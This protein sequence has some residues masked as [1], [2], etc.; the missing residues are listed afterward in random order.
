MRFLLIQETTGKYMMDDRNEVINRYFK[1][2]SKI[3]NVG[4][5]VSYN[6]LF[7]YLHKTEFTYNRKD[8][9][10]AT[11]GEYLRYRFYSETPGISRTDLVYLN[12][13]C[14]MFEMMIALSV[15]CEETI[16]D[17]PRYG[18]RTKQWFWQM[19]K[20]LGLNQM[21]D[22]CFDRDTFQMAIDKFL[23]H[24]YESNGKG[25]LFTI[26]ECDKDL[27]EYD[28]WSQLCCYLDSISGLNCNHI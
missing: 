28:I 23:N 24:K 9:S 7:Q 16:M 22:D 5:R 27:R 6:K 25:G 12:G 18:N 8:S 20:S 4:D 10:R 2:L 1:W 13:P 17:D 19:I 21:D 26:R 11:D 14:S 3:V 15:R